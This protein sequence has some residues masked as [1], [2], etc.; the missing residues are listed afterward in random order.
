M[1]KFEKLKNPELKK[2][3][4]LWL[5]RLT[6]LFNNKVGKPF[7]ING[8][9][10]YTEDFDDNWE[11]WLGSSLKYLNDES[12]KA[13]DENVFRPV[14]INFNP[15]G[16]HFIDYF[17]GA[18]VFRLEDN[19]WQVHPLET[20]IGSL[21]K[22]NLNNLPAWKLMKDFTKK[23]LDYNF[24]NVTFGLPTIASALNVAVNLYGQNILL[25]MIINPEAAKHDLKIINDFLCEI[26][27]WYRKNIPVELLQCIIPHERHLPIGFGQLCGCTTQL[28]SEQQYSEFIAPLDEELLSLYPNGGM[29]HLCGAH[30]QHNQIWRNMKSLRALQLNDRASEDLETYFNELREDQIIYVIPCEEMPVD[31]ILKITNGNRVVIIGDN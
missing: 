9:A 27:N 12:E 30:S 11:D 23:F 5:G 24:E 26:H 31:K 19:S 16:V 7:F 13:F 22:P 8:I 2:Y 21:E 15:H 10:T 29:I 28:I 18:D 4:E 14:C 3:R 25:E 17:F 1:N 6:D 20:P